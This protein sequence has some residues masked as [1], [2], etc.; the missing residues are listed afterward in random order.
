MKKL[1]F[2]LIILVGCAGSPT[3]TVNKNVTIFVSGKPCLV[4]DCGRIHPVWIDVDYTTKSDLKSDF[5]ADQEIKP[6][7]TIPFPGL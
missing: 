3:V 7:T 5:K 4:E 6:E 1:F 2:L